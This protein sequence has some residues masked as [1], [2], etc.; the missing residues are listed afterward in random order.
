M[1][2]LIEEASSLALVGHKDQE[3]NSS[4]RFQLNHSDDLALVDKVQ[5]QQVLL[6]LVRNAIEAM[7]GSNQRELLV[8]TT[9]TGDM[10]TVSVAD[11]GPGIAPEVADQL[12]KPFVTTKRQ[13][14][15]VGLIPPVPSSR[16]MAGVSGL[17][18]MQAVVPYF[19]IV[20]VQRP[21]MP[22][23]VAMVHVIDD[24]DAF[25]RSYQFC[26]AQPR[27]KLTTLHPTS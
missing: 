2:K 11:T 17:N 23:D 6:N 24:D 10:L 8:S 12:F 21:V 18:Q 3:R 1:A 16:R 15:G 7:H 25:R 26:C 27:L 19:I 13:G 20:I 14:M 22:S 9:L 4:C 5:I